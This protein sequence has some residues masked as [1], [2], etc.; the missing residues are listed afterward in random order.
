VSNASGNFREAIKRRGKIRR[1]NEMKFGRFQGDSKI[2]SIS[3]YAYTY[4]HIEI[5]STDLV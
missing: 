5:K 2:H 4:H 1:D 3:G